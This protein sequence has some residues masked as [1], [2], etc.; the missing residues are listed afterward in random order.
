MPH[1]AV[2][3][4]R[5]YLVN[6]SSPCLRSRGV[7]PHPRHER[8]GTLL[9]S[10]R[11]GSYLRASTAES[12]RVAGHEDAAGIQSSEVKPQFAAAREGFPTG[13]SAGVRRFPM[14][15]GGVSSVAAARVPDTCVALPAHDLVLGIRCARR[16]GRPRLAN[17]GR[18]ATKLS[19]VAGLSLEECS[20]RLLRTLPT[21]AAGAGAEAPETA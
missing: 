16:R 15:I 14:P 8:S 4:P 17:R 19:A 21:R 10:A 13:T 18:T 6:H 12:R 9:P 5:G 3:T 7:G 11:T 20:R 2:L 1:M